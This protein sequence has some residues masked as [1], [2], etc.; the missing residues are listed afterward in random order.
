[1]LELES[2]PKTA[3]VHAVNLYEDEEEG[4]GEGKKND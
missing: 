2:E 1:M 4:K 3:R